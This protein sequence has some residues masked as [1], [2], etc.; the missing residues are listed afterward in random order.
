MTFDELWIKHAGG[1]GR[2]FIMGDQ[3]MMNSTAF[4]SRFNPK[5][6]QAN[7]LEFSKDYT[8]LDKIARDGLV[9]MC[10]DGED[11]CKAASDGILAADA[12]K[13]TFSVTGF[14]G[15][16]VWPIAIWIQKPKS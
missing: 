10:V 3:V 6:I 13:E 8:D 15:T 12:V 5:V 7:S 14:D 11:N 9:V 4:Y 1:A 16:T 2:P